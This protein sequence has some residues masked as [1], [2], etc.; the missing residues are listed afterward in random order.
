MLK[1]IL[2]FSA[3]LLGLTVMGVPMLMLALLVRLKLGSPVL[4]CQER[5]GRHERLFRMVKFRTMTDRRDGA[6]ELRCPATPADE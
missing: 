1:R 4:F 5:P 3:A 2:D 6:G